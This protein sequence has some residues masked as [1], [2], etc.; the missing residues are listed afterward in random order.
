MTVGACSPAELFAVHEALDDFRQ[1]WERFFG[2]QSC[3]HAPAGT[4]A[5]GLTILLGNADNLPAIAALEHAGAIPAFAAQTESF[6]L[7]ML[8]VD[9][10]AV[11]V[12]RAHDV[13]GWQ[14]AVYAF[15]EA[16]LGVHFVHPFYDI[17]PARPPCPAAWHCCERPARPLR[18]FYETSHTHNGL[19]GT[20]AMTSHFSDV[21]A[22]RWEDW[23]GNPARVKLLLAWAV[24]VRANTILFDSSDP[25]KTE[26][27]SQAVLDYLDARG[28]KILLNIHPANASKLTPH[29][30]CGDDDY[31]Q[32]IDEYFQAF[33][34]QLCVAKP[35]FWRVLAEKLAAAA[36]THKHRLAVRLLQLG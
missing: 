36:R 19:R 11:A 20:T 15:A 5:A 16:Y 17:T 18:V 7:D 26:M 30:G 29:T 1:Y 10:R 31:C 35:G 24:K 4:P 6:A 3:I 22:W 32:N 13:L 21:G 25:G 2:P 9:G 28:L 12:L 33:P 14:Y 23:Q 27:P 8:E 34:R